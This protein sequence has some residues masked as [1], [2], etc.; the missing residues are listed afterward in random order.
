MPPQLPAVDTIGTPTPGL[1]SWPTSARTEEDACSN[2]PLLCSAR[3]Q[4]PCSG[5]STSKPKN[6]STSTAH[7]AASVSK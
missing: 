6:S 3:P 5:T 1:R 7:F 4:Q 2:S